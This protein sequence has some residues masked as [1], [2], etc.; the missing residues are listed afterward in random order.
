R[1]HGTFNLRD[2]DIAQGQM[3]AP[4]DTSMPQEAE[5][6]AAFAEIALDELNATQ[7]VIA[8]ALQ[9]IE[10]IEAKTTEAVGLQ[11]TPDFESLEK[12]LSRID[13]FLRD[14]Q[15]VHPAAQA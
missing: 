13:N 9:A 14:K 11:G 10:R 15:A 12:T 7:A 1:A 5:I 2:L 8:G 6:A 3:P 4:P